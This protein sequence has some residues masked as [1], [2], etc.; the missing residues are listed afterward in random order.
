MSYVKNFKYL[1]QLISWFEHSLTSGIDVK[2]DFSNEWRELL[3]ILLQEVLHAP[4]DEDVRIL[5]H[6]LRNLLHV[7]VLLPL[8]NV[9]VIW[10]YFWID[11]HR[12]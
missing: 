1:A 10:L 5:V 12:F 2:L 6:D 11:E 4:S 8:Y 7:G 3:L 9:H